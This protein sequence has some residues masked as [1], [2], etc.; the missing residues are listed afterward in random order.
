MANYAEIFKRAAQQ[1]ADHLHSLEIYDDFD[2]DDATRAQIDRA[3]FEIQ[4]RIRK[5]TPRRTRKPRNPLATI[6]QQLKRLNQT[7]GDTGGYGWSLDQ[8]NKRMEDKT[9]E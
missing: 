4:T 5:M 7:L 6:Q 3:I 9:Q 8:Y 2:N 1:A